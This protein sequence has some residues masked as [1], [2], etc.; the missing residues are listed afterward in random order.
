QAQGTAYP[1][2]SAGHLESYVGY[3]STSSGHRLREA[4]RAGQIFSPERSEGSGAWSKFLKSL[5]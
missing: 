3:P 5:Y 2:C 1:A 4:C